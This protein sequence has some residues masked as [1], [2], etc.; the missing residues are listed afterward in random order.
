MESFNTIVAKSSRAIFIAVL[1]LLVFASANTS[2]NA[3][4]AMKNNAASNDAF[5][6]TSERLHSSWIGGLNDAGWRYKA[7]ASEAAWAA[8]DF[9]DRDWEKLNSPLLN[10]TNLPRE[11]WTGAAWFRL[12]ISVD[13]QLAREPVALRLSHWG[14]SEIYLDGKL[15]RG[16]GK[17]AANNNA[18]GESGEVEQNPRGLPVPLTFETSG[19]HIIAV[20]YSFDATRDL[21]KGVGAWLARGRFA[22]GFNIYIQTAN[23]AIGDNAKNIREGNDYKLFA[24]ILYAFALLHF[25]LFVFYHKERTNLFYSLFAFSLAS[26]TTFNNLAN[27][28]GQTAIV[29]AIFFVLFVLGY[30]TAFLALQSFLYEAFAPRFSKFFW[31]TC[32]L[33]VLLAVVTVLFVRDR[34]TLYATIAFLVVSLTDSLRL[35]ALAVSQRREGAWI[36]AGGVMVFAVGILMLVSHEFQFLENSQLYA[37]ASDIAVFLAVP[38]AVSIFLARN[39]ARTNHHLEAQLAHVRELSEKELEQSRRAAE[40][41]LEREQEKAQFAIVEAENERRAKELEEARQ[42]QLSML[43]KKLPQILNLEIA[44]YMKPATEVGGDY[45]DFHVGADGTL[46]VAIGDAT[47]HGLKAGSVVTATKS[48]FNAFADNEN[49][50][51]IFKQTS[52]ALKK[53]NLRGLFMAMAMVKIKGDNLTICAAGMPSSLIY[54]QATGQVEE[55]VIRAM[56]LGSVSNFAYRQQALSLSAGDCIVLMSDGFPEMFNEQNEMLADDAA[57]KVLRETADKSA[58]E[59]INRFVEVGEKWA[60]PRPPDDDVTFVVVKVKYNG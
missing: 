54:R 44:A 55:V 29:S 51:Q 46:T 1:L 57:N 36:I 56:P 18:D 47:G 27:G 38:V 19:E 22:P 26:A 16:F 17:I 28:S 50:P 37:D 35:V 23:G 2:Q 40:L 12:H 39:F 49:I 34:S 25:L 48:L 43:P 8:R 6:L 52:Q 41:A 10:P 30:A 7:G 4:E 42:L 45:Y 53:M 60:G 24:G 13:E 15:L 33:F 59:I 3:D 58:Q 32:L 11:G 5:V 21:S 9:D 14:A 31:F 20:R